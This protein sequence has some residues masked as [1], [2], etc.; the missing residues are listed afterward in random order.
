MMNVW[1]RV[2]RYLPKHCLHH[3]VLTSFPVGN[4]KL[5]YFLP[6]EY[7]LLFTLIPWFCVTL[8]ITIEYRLEGGI[9]LIFRAWDRV[10]IN[11]EVPPPTQ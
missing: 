7:L 10:N 5:V 4:T 9:R 2:C 11:N 8:S 6:T 3:G 1:I